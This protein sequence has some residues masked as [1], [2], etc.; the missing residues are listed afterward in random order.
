VIEYVNGKLKL[1]QGKEPRLLISQGIKG[2]RELHTW[3]S[4]NI[5]RAVA[6]QY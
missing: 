3:N 2:I 1:V 5:S 4:G 6:D